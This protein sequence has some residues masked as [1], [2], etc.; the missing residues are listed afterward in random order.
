M[1]NSSYST[2]KEQDYQSLKSENIQLKKAQK[3]LLETNQELQDSNTTFKKTSQKKLDQ[4]LQQCSKYESQI[5]VLIKTNANLEIKFKNLTRENSILNIG[6][7]ENQEFVE[8]IK[9][10]FDTKLSD[11]E[12][13]YKIQIKE[14]S[15]QITELTERLQIESV[16]TLK[17][18]VIRIHE[19][20]PQLESLKSDL[21][22]LE[23]KIKIK[24]AQQIALEHTIEELQV[25]NKE[26]QEINQNLMDDAEHYQAYLSESA[27]DSFL[28]L[29]LVNDACTM[30]SSST[31]DL[32]DKDDTVLEREMLIEQVISLQFFITKF[33]SGNNVLTVQ[34]FQT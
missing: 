9:K 34:E 20:N 1:L 25:E 7:I 16:H 29:N 10:D 3:H 2:K 5:S 8:G 33:L 32:V 24:T 15:N 27:Q 17:V 28:K 14:K 6:V 31:L 11:L 19:S 12:T 22:K 18:D 13:R 26:L 30:S 21:I 23:D 4:V